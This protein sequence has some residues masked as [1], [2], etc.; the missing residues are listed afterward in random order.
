MSPYG[1]IFQQLS[2]FHF[3]PCSPAS[4]SVAPV[5]LCSSALPL[6][7][8]STPMLRCCIAAFCLLS[9]GGAFRRGVLSDEGLRRRFLLTWSCCR[10]VASCCRRIVVLLVDDMRVDVT[11]SPLLLLLLM[12]N[13]LI[14]MLLLLLVLRNYYSKTQFEIMKSILQRIICH[15]QNSNIDKCS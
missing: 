4:C 6:P 2:Y 7:C 13:H 3:L 5:L 8:S 14:K 12:C 15:M 1:D 10:I 9:D 11:N